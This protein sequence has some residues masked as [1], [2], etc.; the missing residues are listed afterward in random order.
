VRDFQAEKGLKVDG[1]IGSNTINAI[2]QETPADRI[3]KLTL[4]MERMRWLPRR[5]GQRYVLLNQPAFQ[6]TFER[7]DGNALTMR[8][9][10][11]KPS[12][13]TYFFAD[14]I[15]DVEYNPY[16]NVPR[17]IIV[18]EMLP[19]LYNNPYYLDRNGYEVIN[20]QGRQISSAQVDW[21][22]YARNEISVDVRQL[23]GRRNALGV[24]KIDFPNRHAIY[25]HDTPQ[26]HLFRK[27][28][29]AFSHG[30]VRLEHP[31]EMAAALLGKPVSYVEEQ[32]ARGENRSEPVGGDIPVYLTYFT[33]WPDP[34]GVVQ[35]HADVYDRDE[36][37]TK[38]LEKT[39]AVR[40]HPAS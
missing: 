23:P 3:R 24:L 34:D 14:T 19:K 15:E 17:S 25:M 28:Q 32:I 18:N 9:I 40:A 21:A 26:K 20:A 27:E 13:Q 36:H 4:A 38:A 39:N 6:V 7:G 22:A 5:L 8:A 30:C 1:I 12:N 37:L 35:Y 16:W 33:A 2:S 29:R 11:G 31:P 10:V